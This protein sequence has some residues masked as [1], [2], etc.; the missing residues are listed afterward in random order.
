MKNCWHQRAAPNVRWL[1]AVWQ[2]NL[3]AQ[4]E[5]DFHCEP[6]TAP[7]RVNLEMERRG[8]FG[9]GQPPPAWVDVGGRWNFGVRDRLGKVS[10]NARFGLGGLR[11]IYFN[12]SL[13]LLFEP[14]DYSPEN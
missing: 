3:A 4:E 2:R 1:A 5:E 13:T 6:V 12:K 10:L 7:P 11:D 9:G 14:K 8:V